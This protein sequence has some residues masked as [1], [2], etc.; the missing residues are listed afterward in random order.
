[1]NTNLVTE[2]FRSKKYVDVEISSNE[3]E[4]TALLT[5]LID[6]IGPDIWKRN[7]KLSLAEA[8]KYSDT[9]SLLIS[10]NKSGKAILRLN[11]KE[12]LQCD[13]N[14]TS[15]NDLIIVGNL[16]AGRPK[17]FCKEDYQILNLSP[18]SLLAIEAEKFQ[19]EYQNT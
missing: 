13:Q 3:I 12:Q 1:M 11:T 10:L 16:Y 6:L 9:A 19:W 15:Q 17:D 8:Q 18:L 14:L 4:D 5:I 2:S 7:E